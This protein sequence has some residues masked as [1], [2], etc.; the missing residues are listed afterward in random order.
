M[1][2]CWVI[3]SCCGCLWEIPRTPETA[4]WLWSVSDDPPPPAEGLDGGFSALGTRTHDPRSGA[5]R[6]ERL[7]RP[8]PLRIGVVDACIGEFMNYMSLHDY[9][10]DT[11]LVRTRPTRVDFFL[12]GEGATDAERAAF[13]AYNRNHYDRARMILQQQVVNAGGAA[14]G[15]KHLAVIAD[16]TV[17]ALR[18]IRPLVIPR[19]IRHLVLIW[20][21]IPLEAISV[22]AG[23]AVERRPC[24]CAHPA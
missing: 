7:I 6:D 15:D 24:A 4:C 10:R 13:T 12:V 18:L 19:S 20:G 21:G 8:D 14:D 17:W 22:P 3:T 1:K 23:A 16:P 9:P 11:A 5:I 2:D